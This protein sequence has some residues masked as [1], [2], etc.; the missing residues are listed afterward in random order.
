[1][2]SLLIY[3][4]SPDCEEALRDFA[5]QKVRF[6]ERAIASTFGI[7]E[8]RVIESE[9]PFVLRLE[10]DVKGLARKAFLAKQE[11]F[12]E[13]LKRLVVVFLVDNGINE[14]EYKFEVQ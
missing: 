12:S 14:D 5:V 13:S 10:L 6:R 7:V 8:R 1:M 3:A 4:F 9:N 11:Q 2:T